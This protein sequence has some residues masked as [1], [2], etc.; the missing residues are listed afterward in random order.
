M[1]EKLKRILANIEKIPTLPAT[2]NQIISVLNNPKSSADDVNHAV[3]TDIG[4]SSKVLKIVNSSYFGLSK[5]VGS[6]TQAIVIL[7][8][9]TIQSLALTASIMSLFSHN[10]NPKMKRADFW[11]HCFAVGLIA[12]LI[13]R[14]LKVTAKE[15][16]TYFIAGLLHDIGKVVLDQYMHEDFDAVLELASLEG[17]SVYEAEKHIIGV[18]H[19]EIGRRIAERWKLP[20]IIVDCIRYHHDPQISTFAPQLAA[21]VYLADFLC[22]AKR[23]GNSG[24]YNIMNFHEV[25][26]TKYNITPDFIRTLITTTIDK[27]ISAAQSMFKIIKTV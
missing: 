8:F 1:N 26:V 13:G 17:L 20:D 5:K 6:I 18:T 24:D 15:I 27:E 10:E 22:K 19:A 25:L 4:L 3:S 21:T 2:I 23:I 12:K 14:N 7:G 16:E 9:N 11:D